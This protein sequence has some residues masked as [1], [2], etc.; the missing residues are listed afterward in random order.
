MPKYV[1][2]MLGQGGKLADECIN[3]GYIGVH[4]DLLQDLSGKFPDDWRAFNQSFIPVLIEADPERPKRS[5]GLACAQVWQLGHGLQDGD[6]A[7][8]PVG[9]DLFRIGLVD[10][11]YKYIEGAELP[12]QRPIRWTSETIARSDMSDALQASMRAGQTII[13]LDR[14]APEIEQLRTGNTPQI[15]VHGGE[16]VEDPS[17]FAMERHL[18]AFLVS[19]W[20]RAGLGKR[21]DILE[22]D[23]IV[24]GQQY[25]TEVGIIDILAISKDKSEL[26]VIELKRGRASDV[27]VGQTLRYMGFVHDELAD[28]GQQVR[29]AIIALE[30]GEKLRRALSMVPSI[31]FYKYRID[32]ELE[33][34]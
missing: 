20:E 16:L 3:G 30:D 5:A 23:G 14:H 26:L 27:V 17:A 22:E 19:N 24:V 18:E 34:S 1:R 32:F 31:T 33:E 9:G 8:A 13:V 2:V 10:G 7:I 28:E 11:P 15:E 6:V 21:Y 12:H 4:Y 29:G 25:Q